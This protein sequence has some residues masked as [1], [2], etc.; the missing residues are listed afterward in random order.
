MVCNHF[1]K[2]F[3]VCSWLCAL[4]PR[5]VKLCRLNHGRFS[6]L[7]EVPQDPTLKTNVWL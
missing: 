3:S 7:W 5:M 4:M 2:Q 6:S 1:H